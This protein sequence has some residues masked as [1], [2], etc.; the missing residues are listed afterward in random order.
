MSLL[1]LDIL[2][3]M[4]CPAFQEGLEK[5]YRESWREGFQTSVMMDACLRHLSAFYYEREAFDPKYPEK[6]H[7]GAAVFCLIA[8]Y[9]SW[10][11]HE[12]L[13]DRPGG[14]VALEEI[15]PDIEPTSRVKSIIQWIKSLFNS[16]KNY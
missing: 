12:E 9:N 16:I 6:H 5:Y 2:A 1:P 4:L 10:K 7:L 3:E 11:N 14:V 8:M 15:K 13:D